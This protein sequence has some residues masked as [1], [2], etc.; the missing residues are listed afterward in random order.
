MKNISILSFLAS[1]L[2]ISPSC[3]K[4]RGCIEPTADNYNINAEEDDGTCIPSR[5]K[6]IGSYNYT[7]V[8]TDVILGGDGL[9][10][11]NIQITEANTGESHF[12][13]NLDGALVLQGSTSANDILME[14]HVLEDVYLGFTFNRTFNGAG[15]WLLNDSIDF[16]F[17]LVTLL[18]IVEGD[19]L[20]LTTIPQ[21]YSYY[22][23]KLPD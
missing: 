11:G 8:W 10:T 15:S 13:M 7:K 19:P 18:P 22:C 3:T 12:N 16:T 5:D 6:L 2:V 4:I 20:A 17:N 1:V 9:E 14:T 23:T 21:T